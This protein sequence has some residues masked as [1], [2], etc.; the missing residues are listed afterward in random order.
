MSNAA[1]V[2]SDKGKG[3]QKENKQGKRSDSRGA[4]KAFPT[5]DGPSYH[6]KEV[7]STGDRL[8]LCSDVLES[9]QTVTSET[10]TSETALHV[11]VQVSSNALEK[12]DLMT[13]CVIPTHAASTARRCHL[14]PRFVAFC[15]DT[16]LTPPLKN[17]TNIWLSVDGHETIQL[18]LSLFP[19]PVISLAPRH[20]RRFRTCEFGY[21]RGRAVVQTNQ[22]THD[23]VTK[24]HYPFH[25]L[26]CDDRGGEETHVGG[27]GGRDGHRLARVSESLVL[28]RN[29]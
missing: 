15:R 26:S 27:P 9:R 21:L 25:T 17:T 29:H 7:G 22:K 13:H 28:L 4:A 8:Q 3:Q 23:G 16:P 6:Q 1:P 19:L 14:K 11:T 12:D 5:K 10:V 2:H 20:E 24:S 18:L